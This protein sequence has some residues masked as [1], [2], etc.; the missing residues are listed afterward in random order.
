MGL[1]LRPPPPSPELHHLLPPPLLILLPR[2]FPLLQLQSLVIPAINRRQPPLPSQVSAFSSLPPPPSCADDGSVPGLQPMETDIDAF[3][4]VIDYRRSRL[5]NHVAYIDPDADI[6]LHKL[7]R[8]VKL[9]YPT[10]EPFS[11]KDPMELLGFL[12]T[13]MEAFNG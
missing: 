13:M 9:L 5:A 2:L 4:T 3:L 11:G 1:K 6:S 10:L 12:S 8:K 7:K